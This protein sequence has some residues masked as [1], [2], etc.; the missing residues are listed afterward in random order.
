MMLLM[1]RKMAIHEYGDDYDTPPPQGVQLGDAWRGDASTRLAD[2]SQSLCPANDDDYSQIL[3]MMIV[4]LKYYQWW[5]SF[6]NNHNHHYHDD[7]DSHLLPLLADLLAGLS[8]RLA[9]SEV[10][11]P[12]KQRRSFWTIM[13]KPTYDMWGKYGKF[14]WN[15]KE[16][17]FEERLAVVGPQVPPKNKWCT[18]TLRCNMIVM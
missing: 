14:L 11:E 17:T 13:R 18:K 9:G 4:I 8:S 1:A 6:L 12:A 2:R 3:P 5:W 7:T 10:A 16:I 15:I